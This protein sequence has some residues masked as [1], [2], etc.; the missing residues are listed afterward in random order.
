MREQ[1]DLRSS[2]GASTPSRATARDNAQLAAA[3]AAEGLSRPHLA[4]RAQVRERAM[5]DRTRV[6]I[7]IRAARSVTATIRVWNGR[8]RSRRALREISGRE[9]LGLGLTSVNS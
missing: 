7:L 6:E 1:I 9:L 3:S 5:R 8:A 4:D 2:A